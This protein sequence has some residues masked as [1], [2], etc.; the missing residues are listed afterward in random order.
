MRSA[1]LS[2]K[3][4]KT[5][6]FVWLFLGPLIAASQSLPLPNA[7]AHNDYYHKRPLFDALDNGY[8][9]IE[10]DIFLEDDELIVAHINPFFRSGKTLESMYL[11]PLAE[12][13]AKN[14]GRVYKDYDEP[15]ILMIDIKTAADDTYAA[16]KLLLKRY[17]AILTGYDHGIISPGAVTVVLSGHKPY[18]RIKAEKSRLAFIDEDLRKTGQDTTS[19]NVYKLSSCKYSKVL[20]WDGRGS[21]PDNE[22]K[23]LCAYVAM[24]HRFGK[25]VRL[26]ASPENSIVWEELLKC[27][28]DLINTD[29][30]VALK[31][32]LATRN[33][34]YEASPMMITNS[35]K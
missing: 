33:A 3:L 32:F 7:F 11:K 23:R 30:L 1:I 21:I 8:T 27:G 2:V 12:H 28:V 16:L 24:A 5:G 4:L 6:I 35:S 18:K 19:A 17:S 29:Q 9:S 34:S 14:N 26:W 31:N 22:Q 20:S 25:K 13:I 15:V 10:A